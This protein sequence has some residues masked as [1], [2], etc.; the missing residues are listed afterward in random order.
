MQAQSSK[1]PLVVLG[2]A[3]A[4]LSMATLPAEI[5]KRSKQRFL[6]TIGCLVA[7]YEAGIAKEIRAYVE[8]HGGKPEA[9]LLPGGDKTSVALVGLAHATY[10][11][12]LELTDAA[13]RG[14]CHPGN[15]IVPIALAMAE[16]LSCGGARILPAIA[17][18]YEVEIRIGRSV[19]PSA[20]YRGWWTPGLF[21]AIGPAVTA[22]H[23]MGL[24]AD[25]LD[26]TIG[27]VL[28]ISPTPMIRTSEEGPTVKWLFGGQAASSGVLAAEMAARGVRGMRDVVNGW[29]PVVGDKTHPERLTEGID[30]N[31]RFTQWEMTSGVLT[32]Y[33]AT[34]GPLTSPLDATFDLIAE[35][36]IG[37]DDIAAIE[38]ICMKRTALFNVVHPDNEVAARGSLPFCVA[39]AIVTRDRAQLL[40]PV[41]NDRML[42]DATIWSLS[43]KVKITEHEE[44]ERKYPAHS[45][46]RVIITLKNG[47][48]VDKEVDRSAQPRYL[49][50]EDS[51][52]EEKF[53]MIAAPVIGKDNCAR[54]IDIVRK[55]ETVDRV[56]ELVKLLRPKR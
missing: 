39:A 21:G 19:F 6:D 7:G 33:Y 56:D 5:V 35:H 48:V 9:T 11:H 41:F 32:K 2:K 28:N 51:D 34:V 40:G 43:E 31:A 4:G 22:A 23:M 17:A 52:I 20:F 55:F 29:L 25:R 16:K 15:E 24:D 13:P 46:C 47:K 38:A 50:P 53:R 30:A 10:M 49:H 42:K 18:G 14:T 3:A 54:V 27:I 45:L 1:D 12:G 44:Y 8:A 37:V 36:N 26:Q